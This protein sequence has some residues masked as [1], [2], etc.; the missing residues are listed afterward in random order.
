MSENDDKVENQEESFA[1]LFEQYSAGL[2]QDI[3]QGD[4]IKGTII[5]I[6]T[7]SV[8]VDTGTKSDGVV[9][10]MELLDKNGECPYKAGDK[11]ELYVI[12]VTESEVILSKALSGSGDDMVLLDA[13]KSRTP[14]EGKV[15]EVI[16]GGFHIDISGKRAFCPVSQIDVTY[17]EK[18]ETYLG[19]SGTF[20][21][22]RYEEK[23]R[24][25][26]VSRREYLQI[27]I[28]K[29]KK[30]FF[31]E[32]KADDI[33]EA[34]I[35]K[36]M[37]YGAFA[38]LIPG[39]EGMIHISELSWTRVEKAEEA[40]SPKDVVMVKVLSIK[41]SEGD[42][43]PKISLS[44]KQ[45]ATDP[46][47]LAG[48]R[49]HAGD[50]LTGTVMRCAPF[51]AFVEIAPGTEGL[52]HVS[53]MSYTKRILK[54]EDAVSVGDV[55][56]VVVKD[57]DT[58]KKRISLS[59]KDAHGDPWAGIAMKYP[60]GKP[61]T[62]TLEKK[63]SFGLFI[64][65]EPGV[66]GLLPKSK[67]S[68]SS[69]ASAIDKLKAGDAITLCVESVDEEKRRISLALT[70]TE[71]QDDWKSFVPSESKNLGTMGELLKNAMEK[72]KG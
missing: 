41:E 28:D 14:V 67:I 52:V 32:L 54:P 22:T 24:N 72:N 2:N 21:I 71:G 55:V 7:S 44:I 17:V 23:G 61:V 13:F 27:D 4:R 53:E 63:E 56:Q 40:V 43:D 9:D 46:W 19:E 3:N 10:K 48:T 33:R 57:I 68:Q 20:F 47:D 70:P 31:K 12:S 11:I 58:S 64:S 62:G 60:L 29:K 5:S 18:P 49:F 69:E 8:Y 34:R 16:K 1:E 36:I 65:L 37:P 66:T 50:Q 38:E 39:V 35:T 51:G 42:K 59:M 26:V 30:Q 25:I 15:K 45:T 6:G